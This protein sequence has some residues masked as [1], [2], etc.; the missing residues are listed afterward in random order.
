[1]LSFDSGSGSRCMDLPTTALVHV[2]H[3]DLHHVEATMRSMASRLPCSSLD[4]GR[5]NT[6]SDG[7][8]LTAAS[9]LDPPLPTTALVHVPHTDLHHVEATMRSMAS[10]L[11]CSSLDL[12]RCNTS[13]DGPPLTTASPLDP[14]LTESDDDP[15]CQLMTEPYTPPQSSGSTVARG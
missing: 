5:C 11:S 15:R 7:P 13:S 6:S 10:R 8:L 4:L 1:M 14:R 3:T 9:P 2:P 12:G